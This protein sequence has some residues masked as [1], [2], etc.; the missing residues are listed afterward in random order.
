[1]RMRGGIRI[2]GIILAA[3]RGKRM[4][5][6]TESVAKCMIPVAGKPLLQWSIDAMLGSGAA[7]VSVG[8]GWKREYVRSLISEEMRH[9]STNL[10]DVPNY[11]H[12]PLETLIKTSAETKSERLL[13][14]P[15]DALL[16][17]SDIAGLVSSHDAELTL[18]VDCNSDEGTIVYLD[19][20][21]YLAGIGSPMRSHSSMC[22]SAMLLV[23]EPQ[24]LKRCRAAAASGESHIVPVINEMAQEGSL[25]RIHRIRGKSLDVD[26]IEDIIKANSHLLR[27]SK[28]YFQ[29][30]I[31]IPEGDTMEIGDSIVTD[32]GMAL[33]KGVH[34]C[35]PSLLSS[36][37]RLENGVEIGPDAYLGPN[38]AV[39]RDSR[40]VR[41]VSFGE[42]KIADRSLLDSVVVYQSR[43][44][45][46]RGSYD[47]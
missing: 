20:D 24:F 45:R 43:T 39:G 34:L 38:T 1:M 46:G 40:L 28:P 36:G 29:G 4:G 26:H 33:A 15:A 30:S 6:L 5:P 10:V 44:Y 23:A 31:F 18:A 21:G 13:V 11:A 35:G 47:K 16:A 9:H 2:H 3:G 14:G 12:G 8:L 25:V 17:P 7:R 32:G 22:R 41:T 27:T 37:C 19:D 42:S